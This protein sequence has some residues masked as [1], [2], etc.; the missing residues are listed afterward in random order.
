MYINCLIQVQN[1]LKLFTRFRA[2]D[3]LYKS[4][5]QSHYNKSIHRNKL[6]V[7]YKKLE[8]LFGMNREPEIVLGI[9]NQKKFSPSSI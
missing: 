8:S 7:I 2:F 5:D 4:M 9:K 1:S 6:V 3:K